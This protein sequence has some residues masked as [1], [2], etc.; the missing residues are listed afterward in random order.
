MRVPGKPKLVNP[1]AQPAAATPVLGMF[2]DDLDELATDRADFIGQVTREP[3]Y[4]LPSGQA[5][6]ST[7]RGGNVGD[8]A[9]L[10]SSPKELDFS[11]NPRLPLVLRDRLPHAIK[12]VPVDDASMQAALAQFDDTVGRIET[13]ILQEAQS[14]RI[15]S[16]SEKN[17][18]HDP[19]CEVC[20]SNTCCP[21]HQGT[22]LQRVP[23]IK[24]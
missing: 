17:P 13:C 8:C 16:S 10:C 21:D 6:S 9:L 2:R 20:D 18:S 24:S 4:R 19:R 11:R 12:G 3:G 5:S 15:I 14:G 22:T 23:G 7:R 1:A